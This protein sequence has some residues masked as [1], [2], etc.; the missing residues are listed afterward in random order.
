MRDLYWRSPNLVPV[1]VEQDVLPITFGFRARLYPLACTDVNPQ[2]SQEADGPVF[3]IRSVMPAH[4][5]LDGFGCNI[6]VVKWDGRDVVVKNVCLD[7]TMEQM[8]A[9][10][11]KIAVNRSRCPT[12]EG[13]CG[14][15]IV[16][17]C[18]IRML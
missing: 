3:D 17:D 12:H 8:A 10:E 16:G 11:P 18:G 7:D 1:A 15:V 4:N 13:P 5:R 14:R 9:D 6:G 2:T